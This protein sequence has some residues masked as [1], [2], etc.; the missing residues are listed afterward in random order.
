MP[1]GRLAIHAGGGPSG[2]AGG[3]TPGRELEAL[4]PC[5]ELVGWK[6]R[7]RPKALRHPLLLRGS[8]VPGPCGFKEREAQEPVAVGRT[9]NASEAAPPAE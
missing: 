6:W 5:H 4:K 3:S 2:G 7:K 9:W 1:A 8:V